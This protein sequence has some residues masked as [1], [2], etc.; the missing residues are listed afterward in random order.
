MFAAVLIPLFLRTVVVTLATSGG[1][2]DEDPVLAV[3]A[4]PTPALSNI[5]ERP[6]AS[7]TVQATSTPEPEATPEEPPN[8]GDC[9][10]IRGT[11]YESPE[12]R[13]WFLANCLGGGQTANNGGGGNVTTP[14]GPPVTGAGE[15]ALGDRMII[16]SL[17]VDASVNGVAVPPSGAMPDPVG[18]F[19]FVWYD[20]SNFGGL[21]GYA[22]SGNH[23][24]GC[25]VDSAVYGAVVC[26]NV[27][28]L[29]AGSTIQYVKA[30]GEVVNYTVTSAATYP[31]SSDF[32]GIVAAGSADLT[33][34]TCT[35]TFSGGS[36]NLRSVITAVISSL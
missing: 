12:E 10:A 20:F 2:D 22:G 32:T 27:R 28:N 31:A 23:V 6:T 18:Y 1:G 29:T 7:A 24:V 14:S 26:W 34:I 21:G 16:P 13:E 35:G 11:D 3:N 5:D 30:S 4:S 17:G 19:N 15:F 8:R 9:E 36:Y 25:H 33:I